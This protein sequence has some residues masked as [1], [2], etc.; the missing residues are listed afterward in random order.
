[1]LEDLLERY[2]KEVTPQKKGW[3]QETSKLKVISRY[4][5]AQYAVAR[6]GGKELAEYRD[7]RLREVS[8]KTVRDELVLLGHVFKVA[9]QDW[10]LVLPHGNPI[11]AVRKPKVGNNK[12]DRRLNPKEDTELLSAAREYG[13]PLPSIITLALETGMRRGEIASLR[14]EHVDLKRRVV[15]LPETKNDESRDVPLSSRAAEV[16]SALPRNINGLV[17]DVRADSITQ[18]FNRVC[19]RAGI[20]DLRFHDLRHEATSRFFEKGLNP[21][22]VAAITGHKTLQMLQR[23]THLRAEDLAKML[24]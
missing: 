20:E 21:M 23:Y 19:Q 11:D 5:I 3:V 18:A 9:M 1:M 12:R 17:F 2:R 10:G 15:H 13:E 4:P 7:A 24:G 8:A 6:I 14:W 16:L 22:Q